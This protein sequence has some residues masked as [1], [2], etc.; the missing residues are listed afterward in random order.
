M[1]IRKKLFIPT[2]CILTVLIVCVLINL[3]A[4]QT[5]IDAIY[6]ACISGFG[7]LF[8][9]VDI[10]CL[11]FAL[12]LMF[13]RYGNIR[14]GGEGCKPRFN[15]IAWA[16]MMFTTSCGA[17]LIVYGFLEPS[18]CMSQDAFLSGDSA[19]RAYEYGQMY[20][21]FHWGLNAWCI[22]VP[23]SIAIGYALY[24]LKA[25]NATVGEGIRAIT[26]KKWGK[27]VRYIFNVIAICSAILAPV[28]SIGTGMPVLV[29]LVR[30][31]FGFS[32]EYA[33]AI[34]IGILIVWAAIFLTSTYFGL[35][36]GIQR[37]SNVNITIALVFMVTFALLIGLTQVFATEIN[38]I[39]LLFENLIRLSTYSDPYGEGSFLK[40]WTFSYWAC[41][42]VYMPLMGVFTAKISKGRRIKE[43]AF[44]L[45]IICSL[46]CWMAMAT[47]GNYAIELDSSGAIDIASFLVLGDEAGAIIAIISQTPAP[48]IFMAILLI[49]LFI[50]L[51]TTVDSSAFVAAEMTVIQEE[52]VET[53]SPRWLRIL[54]AAAIALFAFAILQ[55]GGATAVRSL[56]YS[57]GLP[58]AVLAL[59]VMVSVVKML[60][61]STSHVISSDSNGNQPDEAQ[62]VD[63][64][65]D[66]I[67]PESACHTAVNL[68][69]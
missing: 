66:S 45:L 48:Q 35:R 20:A 2:L 56:C 52:N 42:F 69:D 3:E 68:E 32:E 33:G 58:M 44:G 13:G 14:L 53:S 21:H 7:W 43:V 34:Q 28:I 63:G 24:N 4:L 18:Y 39:G 64:A 29:E 30:N 5:G 36:R 65:I 26:N 62:A 9:S 1:R 51:A 47:F 22:Y 8:L 38:S 41:Y 23:I 67:L 60:R 57:A 55:V 37:L 25:K 19:S 17:W 6:N 49:I 15:T 59:L 61:G 50:F 54:W 27:Y 31:L 12:W 16:G 10:C 11:V 46:G 40:G